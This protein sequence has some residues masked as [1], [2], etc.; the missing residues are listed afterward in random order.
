MPYHHYV[1]AFHLAEF[2]ARPTR[3]RRRS[4]IWVHDLEAGRSWPTI[5]AK[6]GGETDY[7]AVQ[8]VV[9]VSPEAA[10]SWISESVEQ[11]ASDVLRTTVQ[12]QDFPAPASWEVLLTYLALLKANNPARRGAMEDGQRQVLTFMAQMMVASP[13]TFER[14]QAECRRDGFPLLGNLS[15][16]ELRAR[17]ATGR[18][19][20]DVSTTAHVRGLPQHMALVRAFLS[21]RPWSLLAADAD[22]PDFACGDRPVV[23]LPSVDPEVVVP[24]GRRTCLISSVSVPAGRHPVGSGAV[25][26][27]NRRQRGAATRFVYSSEP[28][29]TCAEA[30]GPIFCTG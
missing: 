14:A 28:S 24:L 16:D 12:T 30:P 26:E 18:I 17:L 2:S 5:A 3:R 15:L 9:G 20:H 25:A 6:A 22:A 11:R 7:N 23:G 1:S 19:D 29:F 27:V 8:N 10:E 21:E 4:P 13:D